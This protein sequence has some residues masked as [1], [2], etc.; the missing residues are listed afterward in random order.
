[1]PEFHDDDWTPIIVRDF[2]IRV[3][4]Q[5]MAENNVD[6][7]HF[8]YVHGSDGHPR[9]RVHHRRHVQED[10]RRR[11]Q[12]HPRG[13]RPRARRAAGEGL[14][15]LPVLDHADRPRQRARPLDLHRAEGERRGRGRAGRRSFCAGVSQDIPIWENK[16]YKDPPVITKTEKL[17]LEHRR[18]SQQFYS[19]R[20]G[21]RM[22]SWL[23][24]YCINVTDLDRSVAFYEALGLTCTS[25]TEIPQAYEAIVERPGTAGKMQLAQQKEQEPPARPRQRFWKLYVN[26]QDVAATFAAALGAGATVRPRPSGSSA[27]RSR[28]VR[29]RPRRLPRRA[30]RAPPW[31]DGA[32]RARGS[33]STASTSPTSR[34]RSPSTSCWASRAPAAPRSP[35][36]W[37]RSSGA[38]PG[39]EAPARPAADQDGPIGMGSMWKLY[40]N[41]DDWRPAPAAIEA[42]HTSLVPPMRLDRWPVTIAFIAILTAT[43]SSSCSGTTTELFFF[44]FI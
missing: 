2:E 16:I 19:E 3:A 24:Q 13:L 43:R 20:E 33:A 14:R 28:G 38:R 34:R 9:G 22:T 6:F 37:R 30:R 15:H 11:R 4:A 7:S 1:M 41:T 25:R 29:P 8:R 35:K 27:G 39:R 40:V 36:R 17:I 23:G 32:R 12:L 44:F 21:G 10:D 31:R 18:W 26:T 42:G 5:D